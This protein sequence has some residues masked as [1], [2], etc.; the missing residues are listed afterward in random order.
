MADPTLMQVQPIGSTTHHLK[1]TL[2]YCFRSLLLF[3]VF[4]HNF[5]IFLLRDF[6]FLSYVRFS[7][8]LINLW[9]Y[10]HLLNLLYVYFSFFF[11][12]LILDISLCLF[13]SFSYLSNP[14]GGD[15]A[16]LYVGE[17]SFSY[18]GLWIYNII[19]NIIYY[20]YY[21]SQSVYEYI[22][23]F[24][25]EYY[26]STKYRGEYSTIYS[27]YL[28]KNYLSFIIFSVPKCVF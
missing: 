28:L 12:F 23:L 19:H 10:L 16:F 5:R 27:H 17:N 6:I 9:H 18:S 13:Q 3:H 25:N 21:V 24:F 11:L 8:V 22:I 14:S 20:E 1:Q 26:T 2:I 4:P 15:L 7:W